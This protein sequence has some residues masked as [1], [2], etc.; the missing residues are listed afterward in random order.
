MHIEAP[1]PHKPHSTKDKFPILLVTATL[2]S[3][4]YPA[5]L[6]PKSSNVSRKVFW[7]VL[8]SMGLIQSQIWPYSNLQ[9]LLMF[10]VA[11]GVPSLSPTWTWGGKDQGSLGLIHSLG[12]EKGEGMTATYVLCRRVAVVPCWM[13]LQSKI[14]CEFFQRKVVQFVV[15]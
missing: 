3:P 6:T 8:G 12:L 15:P 2:S 4:E 11:R 13:L 1:R 10:T 9:L 14:D 7:P 5:R